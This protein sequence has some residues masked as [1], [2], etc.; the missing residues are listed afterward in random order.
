MQPDTHH[1]ES[2]LNNWETQLFT[3]GPYPAEEEVTFLTYA[4]DMD[5]L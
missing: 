2:R 3:T 1:F 4:V 5:K